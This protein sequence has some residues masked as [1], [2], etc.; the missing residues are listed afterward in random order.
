MFL[1]EATSLDP[2][3]KTKILGAA[4]WSRLE[5]KACGENSEQVTFTL[6]IVTVLSGIKILI[7]KMP[8]RIVI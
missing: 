7:I 3:F 1:E 6:T 8:H 2:R 4:V 5:E